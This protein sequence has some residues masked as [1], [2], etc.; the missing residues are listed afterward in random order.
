[1]SNL[2]K[3]L[4]A[5]AS[6]ILAVMVISEKAAQDPPPPVLVWVLEQTDSATKALQPFWDQ[7]SEIEQPEAVLSLD[8]LAYFLLRGPWD[9]WKIWLM[10]GGALS[11][12]VLVT[13][14]GLNGFDLD[15]DDFGIGLAPFL[16]AVVIKGL[17]V[18]GRYLW[19]LAGFYLL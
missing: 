15:S 6:L 7:A 13:L 4:A 8:Y 2:L 9:V 12:A 19:L 14:C 17:L 1:M 16:W 18:I 11:V 3:G 5:L 10:G